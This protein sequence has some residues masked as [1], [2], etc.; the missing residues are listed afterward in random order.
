MN[1]RAYRKIA[2]KHGVSVSEVKGDMQVAITA[3]YTDPGRNLINIKAQNAVPHKGDIPTN[4][5]FVRYV[6][7]EARRREKEK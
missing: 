1:R 4:D 2:K 7:G 5:E 6:A 3:A